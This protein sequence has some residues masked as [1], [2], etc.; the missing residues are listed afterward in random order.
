MR[1]ILGGRRC[2]VM[3]APRPRRD[4]SSRSRR[5][6]HRRTRSRHGPAGGPSRSPSVPSDERHPRP[7]APA[8]SARRSRHPGAEARSTRPPQG[9]PRPVPVRSCGPRWVDRGAR[10][11]ER[12]PSP[13][14]TLAPPRLG[15]VTQLGAP[16]S[17]ARGYRRRSVPNAVDERRGAQSAGGPAAYLVSAASDTAP[18]R[19]RPRFPAATGHMMG[20]CSTSETS[21][22][23]P[24]CSRTPGRPWPTWLPASGFGVGRARPGAQAGATGAIRAT[25]PWSTPRRSASPSPRSPPSPLDRS[26]TTS[27]TASRSFRRSRTASASRVRRT[28]S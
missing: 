12:R 3:S 14:R 18:P 27:L 23:S 19:A 7:R 8:P 4:R 21:T 26:P 25:R 20:A 22:S 10:P 2:C 5:R 16:S 15:L 6:R 24:P 9:R 11:A 13:G 17:A 28:T 1:S